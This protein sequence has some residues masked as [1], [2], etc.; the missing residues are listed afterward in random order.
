MNFLE[1]ALMQRASAGR[2]SLDEVF[3]ERPDDLPRFDGALRFEDCAADLRATA[4]GTRSGRFEGVL[5]TLADGALGIITPGTL[6]EAVLD[7]PSLAGRSLAEIAQPLAVVRDGDPVPFDRHNFAV[8]DD[9][10]I[11]ALARNPV[12]VVLTNSGRKGTYV[13]G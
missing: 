6:A 2:P 1:D 3:F 13:C 4:A 7:T 12:Y 9:T 5:V 8:A 11:V 10:G